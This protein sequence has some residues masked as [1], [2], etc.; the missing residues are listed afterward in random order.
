MSMSKKLA[1]TSVRTRPWNCTC[2]GFVVAFGAK[3]PSQGTGAGRA[4]G[5][6]LGAALASDA[7]TTAA[8]TANAATA[9]LMRAR[10]MPR[11]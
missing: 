7:G 4:R 8:R 2:H 10:P 1:V 3:Q 6:G 9:A 11:P 5:N